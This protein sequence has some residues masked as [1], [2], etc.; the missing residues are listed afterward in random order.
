MET[1]TPSSPVNK[2]AAPE[3]VRGTGTEPFYIFDRAPFV[4]RDRC[5]TCGQTEEAHSDGRHKAYCK[6]YGTKNL[7]EGKACGDCINIRLC[8]SVFGHMPA[9]ETCDWYPIRFRAK[10]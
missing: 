9:D 8:N 2:S 3:D 4:R 5:V 6:G 7:P 10:G 1:P